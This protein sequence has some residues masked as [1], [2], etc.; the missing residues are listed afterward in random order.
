MATSDHGTLERL[1]AARNFRI[2][3]RGSLYWIVSLATGLPEPNGKSLVFTFEEALA[4]LLSLGQTAP[5][6]TRH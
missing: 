4:M 6:L 2:V 1:A 5:D 3:S